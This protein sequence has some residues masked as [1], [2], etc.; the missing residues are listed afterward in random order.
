MDATKGSI[1]S[2]LN[3]YIQFTVPVY[4]RPYSWEISQCEKLWNDIVHMQKTN[5]IG[6]FVGSIVN[7]AEQAMPIGVQKF[8]IIDGQQRMTT[9]TLLLIALRD[10]GYENQED[11]TI[12]AHSINGV[13]IQND[14]GSGEDKYKMLLTQK[15]KDILIKLIDRAPIDESKRSKLLDNYNFFVEKIKSKKIEPC[16]ILEG[17]GKLQIVNITLDR[18][19][20]DPQLIFESLNSTGMDLSKS[21]L[22]RNYILMGLSPEQQDS[23]YN[24]YWFP[25]ENLFDYSKQ[26]WLMDKFFKHYLTFKYGKI[27]VESKIYE[28]FKNYYGD[29]S[30]EAILNVSKELYKCAKY[31]TNIYY[32]NSGDME[33]DC[34]FKDIKS[35]NMD[36]ASPFLIKVYYDYDNEVIS[37]KEFIEIFRLCE[38]YVFRRAICEMPTNSLNKTFNLA[39]RNINNDNYINSVKAFFIMLDNYKR[40]PSNE[41]FVKELKIRDIYNMRIRNYILSKLENHNNKSPIIIE[42]FTVEH[43]MPQNTNLNESWKNDLGKNYKDIQKQYIH[44]IG[45]LTLTAYNSEM[46]DKSFEDKLNMTGGFKESALRLNSYIVK[47]DKWNKDT[48]EER[49]NKLCKLSEEIWEYPNLS[50]CEM[51]S[52]LL[53]NEEVYTLDSYEY[54]SEDNIALFNALDKRILNISSDVKREFKKLYIA[55]KVESNFVDIV[56]QKSK[57]KLN[58]NMKYSDVIDP[59]DICIDITNKGSWGNGDIEVL[60]DNIEQLD[61]IMDII[62]QSYEKQ[63]DVD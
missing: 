34:V 33:L 63:L 24:N 50:E 8:M 52:F 11:T 47:Q 42:N 32:S 7:I 49:A 38:N 10:Y 31:Y 25:M 12:N 39:V 29:K 4:Q 46:S 54:L 14:Y 55:Y 51:E 27:P 16:A 44:T 5:R 45:N 22:I 56:P 17:I 28:E 62:K 23:I 18:A 53:K 36:V 26:T 9:L 21:D 37:K 40:L 1:I 3:R 59:Y 30:Y 61:K 48:I 58:I 57:F 15:D 20:D 13:C 43:I 2:I 60:Y 6:H 35:L 19:Q 41:E